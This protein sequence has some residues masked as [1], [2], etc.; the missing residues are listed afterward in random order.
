MRPEIATSLKQ[1]VFSIAT[2]TVSEKSS[3]EIAI[4]TTCKN[5]GCSVS[6]EGPDTNKSP[7]AYHPGVPVFHEGLK[8][9]SCCQK[10]TT[11]FNAFLSQIGCTQGEHLWFKEVLLGQ[12]KSGFVDVCTF[13]G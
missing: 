13:L 5:G 8:F 1:Q 4:G 7:C 6:Y 10:R 3:D 11:D 12:K 2:E 9:W